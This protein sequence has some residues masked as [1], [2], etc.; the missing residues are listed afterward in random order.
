MDLKNIAVCLD[1]GAASPL[2]LE[3]AL[4]LA[5]EHNA[6]L[7]GIHVTY[8]PVIVYDPYATWG[9]MLLEWEE[10]AKKKMETQK[11]TFLRDAFDM[12]VQSEWVSHKN[13]DFDAIVKNARVSDI[14]VLGQRDPNEAELDFGNNFYERFVLQVG[15]PTLIVPHDLKSVNRIVNVVIAWDGGRESMRAVADAL[16]LLKRAEKVIVLT[17]DDKKNES[18]DFASAD[19][20]AY[21]ARH[22]VNVIS[23]HR[24]RGIDL[25]SDCLLDSINDLRGDLLVMGGYGHNR[26]SELVLGGMTKAVMKNM[27]VP[28][29]MSH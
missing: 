17:I 21:L 24:D 11:A 18:T 16:P 13:I 19:I 10:A 25:A 20:A 5:A 1:N 3:Y 26:F 6:Y 2:R 22:Q 27:Q 9:P 28:V 8:A 4:K 7:I 15:R 29:L 23:E 12:E 14:C